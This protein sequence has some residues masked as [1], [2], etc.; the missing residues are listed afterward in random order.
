[1]TIGIKD[2]FYGIPIK[3][4]E[5][6]FL[7]IELIPD[8]ITQQCNL[9]K[10]ASNGK[11]CFEIWKGTPRLKQAGIIANNRLGTLLEKENYRQYKL[12]PSL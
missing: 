2:F 3:T 4:H 7:P 8:E 1:M 11:A 5:Y 9:L 6:G 10:I 12:I